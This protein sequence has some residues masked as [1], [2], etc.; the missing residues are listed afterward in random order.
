MIINQ[1]LRKVVLEASP[2]LPPRRGGLNTHLCAP[3]TCGCL[4]LGPRAPR[5][6]LLRPS[7][8]SEESGDGTLS[9]PGMGI[10]GSFDG[11]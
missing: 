4:W 6:T 1:V 3:R 8:P 2:A 9:K 10:P 7:G 5:D 11:F